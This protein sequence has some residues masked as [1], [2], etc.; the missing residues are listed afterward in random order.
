MTPSAHPYDAP[1]V[2]SD[3]SEHAGDPFVAGFLAWLI[4]GAG[5]LYLARRGKGLLLGGSILGVFL[6]GLLVGGG[7][8]VS[9][10]REPIWFAGQI[11]GGL[12]ALIGAG[13]GMGA[14]PIVP[15]AGYEIGVLYTCI[16]ALCN[17]LCVLD[18]AST[19]VKP[20]GRVEPNG[21]AS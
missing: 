1:A 6:V 16:A 14:G 9:W 20:V 3:L 11:F 15:G 4:P 5:Y 12:P 18:C 8:T 10:A 13:V 17:F 19:A 2:D 21:A 7:A